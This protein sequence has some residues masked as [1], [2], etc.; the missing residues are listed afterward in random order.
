MWK[1]AKTEKPET[2]PFNDYNK[3]KLVAGL[4]Q[5]ELFVI[6]YNWG[7]DEITKEK[8][9]QWYSPQYQDEVQVEKWA[10]VIPKLP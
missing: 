5:N 3:S 4:F 8:W 9:E 6:E 7:L 1:D 2:K 10:D